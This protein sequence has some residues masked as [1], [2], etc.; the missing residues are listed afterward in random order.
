MNDTQILKLIL[1]E[2]LIK[3]EMGLKTIYVNNYYMVENF[4]LCHGG[5]KED[6]K[7]VFQ[8]VVIAFYNNI[9][10]KKITLKS[11][12]S[13][14]IYSIARNQWLKHVR[15][16]KKTIVLEA[17]VVNK[18][19]DS[20]NA[21]E[22]MVYSEEQLMIAK[23]LSTAGEKCKHLLQ[24][25]YFEKLKMKKIASN[26]GYASEQVAKNQKSKCMKKLKA[27]VLGSEFYRKNLN[28][29]S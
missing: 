11:K 17:E 6:A 1:E 27:I 22:S 13:T 12:I 28:N 8:D 3:N 19:S 20:E 25:F 2:D 5:T 26:L 14:Y 7:D 9:K 18:V 24:Q 21:F 15:D 10:G 16:N 4:I 23:I 29:K